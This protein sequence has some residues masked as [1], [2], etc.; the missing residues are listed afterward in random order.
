MAICKA[1]VYGDAKISVATYEAMVH[2]DLKINMA[3]CGNTIFIGW[4]FQGCV[5]RIAI[6]SEIFFTSQLQSPWIKKEYSDHMYRRL[7]SSTLLR[8]PWNVNKV[9]NKRDINV[10]SV[11]HGDSRE[12]TL[13]IFNLLFKSFLLI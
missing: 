1:I 3:I 5:I 12:C 2:G 13:Q 7:K 6:F 9:R 11:S 4:R 8:Y 10:Y